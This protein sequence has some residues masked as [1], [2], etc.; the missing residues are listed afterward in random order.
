MWGLLFIDRLNN[1]H[2]DVPHGLHVP[3]GDDGVPQHEQ[4]GLHDDV[5]HHG[6]ALR[7]DHDHDDAGGDVLLQG[8]ALRDDHNHAGGGQAGHNIE[9][10]PCLQKIIWNI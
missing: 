9:Q 7:D 3:D 5:L 8:E 10:N 2:D 1:V 6:Q 4:H